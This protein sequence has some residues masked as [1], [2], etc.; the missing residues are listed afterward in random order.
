MGDHIDLVG[1]L[2]IRVATPTGSAPA[3]LG[4]RR[5]GD[6]DSPEKVLLVH[7]IGLQRDT[8]S[9]QLDMAR[10]AD[11]VAIDM[12]GFGESSAPQGADVTVP[13]QAWAMLAAL[14]ALRWK[15]ATLCGYS[16]G[17]AVCLGAALAQPKRIARLA[18]VAGAALPQP[19]PFSFRLLDLPFAAEAMWAASN[20]AMWTGLGRLLAPYWSLNEDTGLRMVTAQCGLRHDRS[21]VRA[22]RDLRPER[23]HAWA[24]RFP[25]LTM[26]ALLLHGTA[27]NM[28]PVEVSRRMAQLLPHATLVEFAGQG[29]LMHELPDNRVGQR[30]AEF[31]QT[32]RPGAS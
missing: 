17:G 14:D 26:P 2:H 21:F 22:A 13:G 15:R 31:I 25:R 20:L 11:T 28:V 32:T 4:Y 24:V 18:L 3:V 6:P 30:I 1:Q 7:G 27:D 9:G 8:W 23:Y 12:L 29:H 19:I 10:V 5:I 16:M